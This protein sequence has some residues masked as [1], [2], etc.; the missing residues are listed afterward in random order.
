[1]ATA[2]VHTKILNASA[3]EVLRPLGVQQKGRSRFWYDDAK[4]YAIAIEFQPSG[5]VKGSYLNVGIHWL[6]Y[7]QDHWSFDL[8]Y[9]EHELVAF[10]NEDQFRKGAREFVQVAA[11]RI[12]ETRAKL[13]TLAG[14]YA[15]VVADYAA[16]EPPTPGHWCHLHLG[17]IAALIG[18][19]EVAKSK[20][21]FA[22]ISGSDTKW[23]VERNRY[24]DTFL[25]VAD[26]EVA[27]RRWTEENIAKSR[28]LLNLEPLPAPVL[29]SE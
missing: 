23:E 12:C 14:A 4:W 3:R 9:R 13:A 27:L 18:K 15:T 1:M 28:A 10:E 7:P 2:P 26:D 17:I 25:R 5:F 19:T 11:K 21:S 6:W 8:G 22:E 24:V 20:A 16:L 29:P